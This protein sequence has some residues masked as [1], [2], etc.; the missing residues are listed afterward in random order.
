MYA[1]GWLPSAGVNYRIQTAL[2]QN[3]VLDVSTNPNDY[4][5]LIIYQHN[6]NAS[7]QRFYFHS[8]GGN[9]FGIFSCHNNQTV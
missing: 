2:G 4:N 8:L 7:N 1:S 5:N 3:M 9:K 6:G